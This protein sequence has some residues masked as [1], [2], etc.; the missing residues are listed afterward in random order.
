V[1]IRDSQ[2]A[3]RVGWDVVSRGP[4]QGLASVR[5]RSGPDDWAQSGAEPVLMK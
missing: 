1:E 2:V 3:L 4:L 5:Q